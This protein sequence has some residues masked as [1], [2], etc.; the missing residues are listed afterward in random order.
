MCFRKSLALQKKKRLNKTLKEEEGLLRELTD[1]GF[2][3]MN[4][5][6][7]RYVSRNRDIDVVCLLNFVEFNDY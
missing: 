6:A 4:K 1:D 7:N 5:D 2:L 3:I